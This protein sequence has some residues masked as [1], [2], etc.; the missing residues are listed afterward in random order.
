MRY[1]FQSEGL[2]GQRADGSR[3][4]DLRERIRH[5]LPPLGAAIDVDGTREMGREFSEFPVSAD[6]ANGPTAVFRRLLTN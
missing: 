3:V 2:A 6:Q 4:A 1:R 5:Q